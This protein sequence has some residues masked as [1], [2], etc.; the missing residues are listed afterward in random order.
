MTRSW[1]VLWW[2]VLLVSLLGC[3][4]EPRKMP[5]QRLP[6][7]VSV[8]PQAKPAQQENEPP[9]ELL[10]VR[11]L[12]VAYQG[13]HGA[14]PEETR[15]KE[16]ALERARM[17]TR[18]ARSG[19]RLAELVRKYSDR[20]GAS[21]DMGLFRIRPSSPGA[22]GAEVA[23]AALALQ[24]GQVSDPVD[25][26]E[27]YFVI[28]R[29]ADPPV[30]PVRIA[31]RHILVSY[32]DAPHAIPGVTRTQP[33]ARELAET[34]AREAKAN[35]DT[36]KNLA[37]QYTDEPGSKETGGDLGHFGRGQMVPAF[38]KAA[39]ALKV[40]EV[41]DVVETPFGYHVIVRYE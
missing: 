28:E 8:T 3:A 26:P 22:F 4:H 16:Q 34:V 40:G 5:K 20:P 36:W 32:K 24:P 38:E 17:I 18:M 1:M 41:S 39:F 35:P 30:G 25:G 15:T 12:V 6:T 21:E 27:G 23:H 10:E 19:D 14:K 29:R 2:G 13:A 37:A 7:E 11:V 31:A 33:E 9:P